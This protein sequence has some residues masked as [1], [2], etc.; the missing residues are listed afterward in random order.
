MQ[1]NITKRFTLFQIF[2]I[3]IL[4]FSFTFFSYGNEYEKEKLTHTA[5]K[6][7]VK[8]TWSA[9]GT[10]SGKS[11]DFHNIDLLIADIDKYYQKAYT[12]RLEGAYFFKENMSSGLGLYYGGED[13]KLAVGILDNSFSRELQS[14]GKKYG[15]LAFLKNH[16]PVSD[17]YL[18]FITNQTEIYYDYES[19][20][21]QTDVGSSLERKN[22]VKQSFGLGI[23]PGILIFFTEGFAFD[24]N[25]GI[26]GFS[27]TVQD[28]KYTYPPNN[29][30][31]ADLVKQDS[32][33]KS[34]DINLKFD[35]LKVGFGFSY[36]F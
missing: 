12:V 17:S 20:N 14:I 1:N 25:M 24:I 8:G 6:R 5:G 32:K 26:L 2:T 16:I 23:R 21:S 27:H 31:S 10:F 13:N 36:Y 7:L 33:N 29:P 9:G 3:F 19:G 18:F 30:P 15:T 35:L 28:N 4:L 34:T 22:S 11:K